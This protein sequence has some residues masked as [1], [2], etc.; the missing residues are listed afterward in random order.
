MQREQLQQ[1]ILEILDKLALAFEQQGAFAQAQQYAKQQVMMAPWRESAHRQLMRLY[2]WQERRSEALAQYESCRHLLAQELGV[3]PA[4]ETIQLWRQIKEGT[5]QT[6]VPT[7]TPTYGFPA[8][9]TPFIGRQHDIAQIMTQL[10]DKSC[11]ILTLIGPG[12]I[13]KT[14]LSVQVGQELGHNAAQYADGITFIPLVAVTDV[15]LL[16]TTIAQHFGHTI[17]RTNFT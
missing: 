8:Q 2:M 11:R 16:V 7:H 17:N 14:R 4:A 15:G 13:G 12:G 10:S 5:L 3:E 6:A 9:L 1:Q